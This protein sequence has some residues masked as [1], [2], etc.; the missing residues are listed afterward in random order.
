MNGLETLWHNFYVSFPEMRREPRWKNR[1][2][3]FI[4]KYYGYLLGLNDGTPEGWLEVFKK[5]PDM[6]T[7]R[8]EDQ[9]YRASRTGQFPF[10]QKEIRDMLF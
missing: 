9:S 1:L 10:M 3:K 7:L 2:A 4:E 8:R 5:L 6:E